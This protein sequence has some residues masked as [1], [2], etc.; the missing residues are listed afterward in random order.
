[1]PDYLI[2]WWGRGGEGE[3]TGW[4][5]SVR[6]PISKGACMCMIA[7]LV[8]CLHFHTLCCVLDVEIN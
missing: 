7:R 3:G 4:G 1:M 5:T 2:M 8:A 6:V